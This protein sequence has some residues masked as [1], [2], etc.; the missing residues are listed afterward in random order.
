MSGPVWLARHSDIYLD[1]SVVVAAIVPGGPSASV[2]A[3]FCEHLSGPG[4]RVSLSSTLRIE[5]SLAIRKIATKRDRI[6]P[7]VR[8][9]FG[10]DRWETDH[11][12]RQ[13]WMAH[14][15]A[16]FEQLLSS[17]AEVVELPFGAGIWARS[18]DLM[19]DHFLQAHDAVHA[20]TAA[21]YGLRAFA[22]TDADFAR[23]DLL[24]VILLRDAGR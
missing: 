2:C 19:I 9:E 23:V 1:T 8:E 15:V 14:G 11:V 20:A 17:F 12:V 16:Q 5:L 21:A 18:I 24:D 13:R 10:F 22:T 4:S 7:T 6:D 3:A